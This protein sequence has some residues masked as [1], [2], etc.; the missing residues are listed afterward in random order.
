MDSKP[1]GGVKRVILKVASQSSE[2]TDSSQYSEVEITLV[3]DRS[4]Y[5]QQ[6][7]WM[8]S[9]PI[10]THRVSLVTPLDCDISSMDSLSDALYLGF[11]ATL[12]MSCG[13]TIELFDD[14]A[15]ALLL[16]ESKI[17]YGAAPLDMPTREWV[18]E[19]KNNK[20]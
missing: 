5:T 18:F 2:A 11:S 8:G 12:Y 6:A 17:D 1:I 7:E 10:V 14:G 20:I 16:K 15:T 19:A 9:V 4:T 13:S 3:E